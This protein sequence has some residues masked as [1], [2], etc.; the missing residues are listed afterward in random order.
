[1]ITYIG[2]PGLKIIESGSIDYENGPDDLKWSFDEKG[3][4]ISKKTKLAVD[5]PYLRAEVG[6]ILQMYS[7]NAGDNQVW[8]IDRPIGSRF[9]LRSKLKPE[10]NLVMQICPNTNDIRLAVYNGSDEQRWILTPAGYLVSCKKSATGNNWFV[11]SKG[12]FYGT[13]VDHAS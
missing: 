5:I 10:L 4:L 9:V 12:K 2:G 8:M 3:R 11:H 1:L 13:F 6:T 7:T